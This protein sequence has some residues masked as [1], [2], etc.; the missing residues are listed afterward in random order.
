MQ[1]MPAS[2]EKEWTPV[3]AVALHLLL[4]PNNCDHGMVLHQQ[5][6]VGP[7]FGGAPDMMVVAKCST[8]PLCVIEIK[9]DDLE[10]AKKQAKWYV[11]NSWQ[12]GS[13][14]RPM[15]AMSMTKTH[16]C[17][18]MCVPSGLNQLHF[19]EIASTS[20]QAVDRMTSLLHKLQI[21][22]TWLMSQSE[23]TP[24]ID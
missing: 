7:E 21:L 11:V 16:A 1:S 2:G 20:L 5:Q 10:Y 4:F 6:V 13:T 18:E 19:C 23:Y 14:C 24:L 17:V 12:H 8:K 15:L 22:C 9:P 3:V